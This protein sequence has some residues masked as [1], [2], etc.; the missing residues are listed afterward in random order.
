M[1]LR[2]A[3]NCVVAQAGQAGLVKAEFIYQEA[4]FPQ[5]HASTI[6]EASQG[7]VAA[8]FGGTREGHPDVG[9]WSARLDGGKWTSPKQVAVGVQADHSRQPCWNPVLFQPKA[10]P[11]MLFYKVGPSP[12]LWWGMVQISSDG[13]KTWSGRRRL[14]PGILGPIKNKPVQLAD[15]QILCP[16]ST[17]DKGWR[18]HFESTK[19]GGVTWQATK[20]V[21]DG[22]EIA[23]IQPTI[24]TYRDGR[25]QA[26]IRSRQDRIAEVWSSDGGKSWGRMT[27]TN[28]PNPNSGI[29]A[30]TLRDGRQLLVYN[31]TARG[32][33]P[34]NV[35]VSPDGRKWQAALVLEN[36]PGEYSYPAVIQTADGLVHITYTW[37]RQ[38]VKHVVVDPNTL[39]LRPIEG[40]AWPEGKGN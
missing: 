7:L 23:A 16:T 15:G 9:I 30:L 4:P 28:L 34:L 2:L 21:N 1:L 14:P 39:Q 5:C 22:K 8:W 31:H 13:G 24:L 10:G 6:A 26:L 20:P 36:E 18:V 17:E 12:Q 33:W 35:A 27:L 40:I 37:N 25:L 29:D 3:M 19:D 32:R 11:L 38:R